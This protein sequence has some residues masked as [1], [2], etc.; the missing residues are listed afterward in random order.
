VTTTTAETLTVDGVTL[1]TLAHNIR[2]Y[3]GRL[4]V[5]PRK[6]ENIDAIADHGSIAITDRPFQSGRQVLAMWILGCAS[7]G[8]VP[9]GS[10]FRKEFEKNR[11][12]LTRL[13]ARGK[14]MTL[15]QTRPDGS[16]VTA[17]GMVADAMDLSTMA[18]AT[19]AEFNV[20]IDIPR[21]FWE[22]TATPTL[23]ETSASASLPKTLTLTSLAGA[24]A[25]T[26]TVTT[27]VTGP[28]TNAT[29]TE[30]A[31]GFSITC[32]GAIP[33]GQVWEVDSEL[34]TSKLNGTSN[35]QNFTHRGGSRFLQIDPRADGAAP[36]LALSGTAGGTLTKLGAT[37]KRKML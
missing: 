15:V 30:S 2:T 20:V 6:G 22:D 16:T 9:V 36:T 24:T 17:Q 5:P 13:F 29:V 31:S 37:A 27:Q 8:T 10:S 25:P 11:A 33:S 34:F 4:N 21:V 1:N 32:A 26:T 12:A 18:G 35:L 3:E 14:L 7:D 23:H 28:I 19:R